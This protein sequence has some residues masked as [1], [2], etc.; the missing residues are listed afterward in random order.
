M[1]ATRRLLPLLAI[2][3]LAPRLARAEEDVCHSLAG[4]PVQRIEVYGLADVKPDVV[5]DA[6]K[7]RPGMVVSP[8]AL[9]KFEDAILATGWFARASVVI[10]AEESDCVLRVRVE[11]YAPITAVRLEGATAYDHGHELLA[12]LASQTGRRANRAV[13][14]RDAVT[15]ADRYHEDGYEAARVVGVDVGEG[16]V[17]F[18]VLEGRI[19]RIEVAGA[20]HTGAARVREVLGIKPGQIYNAI[21]LISGQSALY[22]TGL[23]GSVG[24]GVETPRGVD[25]EAGE[26]GIVLTVTV[27]ELIAPYSRTDVFADAGQTV[28]SVEA[29]M[30]NLT[31][32]HSANAHATLVGQSPSE[33]A[34][35]G[36][37]EFYRVDAAAEIHLFRPNETAAGAFLG[38][39]TARVHGRRRPELARL[40]SLDTPAG[41]A[42]VEI[43][44][45]ASEG[46]EGIGSFAAVAGL[47]SIRTYDPA[48]T[49]AD[50]PLRDVLA[51]YGRG[52]IGFDLH[53]VSGVE[54]P[55]R[56]NLRAGVEWNGGLRPFSWIEGEG[57]GRLPLAN[58][59][60]L[61]AAADGASLTGGSIPYWREYALDGA[62]G[63]LG[64]PREYAFTRS[65]ARGRGDVVLST[66]RGIAGVALGSGAAVWSVPRTAKTGNAQSLHVEVRAGPPFARL[67]AGVA[68]PLPG[69]HS[70]DLWWYVALSVATPQ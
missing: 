61:E 46:W 52:E 30:R 65:Y 34:E 17:S 68:A 27:A 42:G 38:V 63:P 36:F 32:G 37:D 1:T 20:R 55:A 4:A 28:I 7:L 58:W 13:A 70:S 26:D 33:L 10:V 14:A 3:L 67:R 43:P 39:E 25:A 8:V 44:A 2:A 47:R 56:T 23:F 48:G 40:F 31:K 50:V 49:A 57:E 53:R 60:R 69:A 9:T 29:R 18:R 41:R 12:G 16:V 22:R 11:E 66:F 21:S 62:R 59:L 19:A 64:F 35:V 5:E 6:V 51:G 45:I 15:I 24:F 54:T